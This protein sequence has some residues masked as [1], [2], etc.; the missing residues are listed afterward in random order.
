MANSRLFNPSHFEARARAH[1]RAFLP[2]W[3]TSMTIS[4]RILRG[5]HQA[6]GKITFL[7]KPYAATKRLISQRKEGKEEKW[8]SQSC[9]KFIN[10]RYRWETCTVPTKMTLARLFYLS[11]QKMF[12]RADAELWSWPHM[13]KWPVCKTASVGE[14]R[15]NNTFLKWQSKLLIIFSCWNE[16]PAVTG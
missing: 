14:T 5:C 4:H 8:I 7:N 1:A 3:V 12:G 9:D 11:S 15:M 2:A 10:L 13:Q 16:Q 6:G